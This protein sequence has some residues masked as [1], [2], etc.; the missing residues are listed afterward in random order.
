MLRTVRE[1]AKN[2]AENGFTILELMVVVAVMAIVL[3][4][5]SGSL[6]SLSQA[7]TNDDGLVTEEQAAST[8][9]TQIVHDLR[10]AH[11][12]S[13]PSGVSSSNGVLMQE[14]QSSG[15]TTQVEWV[16]VPAAGSN[17]GTLT[18]YVQSSGGSLVVSGSA[19]SGVANG[20][21]QPLFSYFDDNGGSI[22]NTANIGNCTTRVNVDLVMSAPKS[23]GNGVSNFE[24]SQ[25]VAIT[26]QLAILSQ[27]GS[28]Q[29]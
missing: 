12:I 17:P 9:V 16:Y 25:E 5:A 8:A 20:S 18:R 28:V 23:A 6:I 2:P 13:I 29:C 24:L 4:I 21:T 11:S 3:T 1:R 27:P 19:V 7:T 26:D 15:S 14:N 10:S 22:A